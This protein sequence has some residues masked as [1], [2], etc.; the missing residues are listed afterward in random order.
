MG[1]CPSLEEFDDVDVAAGCSEV[2][3]W[4]EA[5]VVSELWLP[6]LDATA[7][8]P[9][10]APPVLVPTLGVVEAVPLVPVPAL[11]VLVLVLV[12]ALVSVL[13]A[14]VLTSCPKTVGAISIV[15][16][17]TSPTDNFLS[18]YLQ[19][20]NVS[21]TLLSLLCHNCS[22]PYYTPCFFVSKISFL[23]R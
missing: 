21:L 22:E 14:L 3:A 8:S 7:A 12:L 19:F 4:G 9:P 2:C 18:L 23:V 15:P 16:T 11:A 13:L 5:G 6:P 17:E 1:V 20:V 10:A